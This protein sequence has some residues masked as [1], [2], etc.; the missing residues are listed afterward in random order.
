[1]C[2]MVH[3][4]SRRTQGVLR[5]SNE[6]ESE[7]LHFLK[8]KGNQFNVGPVA[9]KKIAKVNTYL[10]FCMKRVYSQY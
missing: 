9:G 4:L 8:F 5:L 10:Y 6:S 7:N 1:M 2:N 3:H